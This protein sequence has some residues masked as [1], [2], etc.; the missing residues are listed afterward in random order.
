MATS[1]H[2]SILA[3]LSLCYFSFEPPHQ[4]L[5]QPVMSERT[6]LMKDSATLAVV[7]KRDMRTVDR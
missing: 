1:T 3:A 6:R 4:T 5:T 7:R 2:K